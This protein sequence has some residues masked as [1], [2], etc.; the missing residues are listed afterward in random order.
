MCS[1]FGHFKAFCFPPFSILVILYRPRIYF[2]IF[3]KPFL[4]QLSTINKVEINLRNL[5]Q[6]RTLERVESANGFLY[7]KV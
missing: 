3:K 7:I 2:L 6:N 1:F 5:L 4:L